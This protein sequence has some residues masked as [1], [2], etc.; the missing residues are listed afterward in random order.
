[1]RDAILFSLILNQGW[2]THS[3]LT[4]SYH[5]RESIKGV[6]MIKNIMKAKHVL[7]FC[8]LFLI[9][10]LLMSTYITLVS[11]MAHFQPK[12]LEIFGHLHNMTLGWQY[13]FCHHA[14]LYSWHLCSKAHG[15]PTPKLCCIMLYALFVISRYSSNM[16]HLLKKKN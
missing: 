4:N 12:I 11:I 15:P 7:S 6:P 5:M 3:R 9:L 2:G 8:T 10:Y 16:K 14:T 1:M 13:L